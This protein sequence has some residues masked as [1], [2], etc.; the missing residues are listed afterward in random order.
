MPSSRP[1]NE[2]SRKSLWS[3]SSKWAGM[4]GYLDKKSG[5]KVDQRTLR[6]TWHRRYFDLPF[7]QSTLSYYKNEEA[8]NKKQ[9]AL[10][11]VEC[12]R[13]TVV[14]K[15]VKGET[16]R[17]SIE[18]PA[19]ELKLRAHTNGDYDAWLEALRPHATVPSES[20]TSL[21]SESSSS[22]SRAS[23][24]GGS[25]GG[26]K[27][28]DSSS[29][30][31][32]GYLEKKS[33]GSEGDHKVQHLQKWHK[34]WFVMQGARLS[35]YKTEESH[36]N[37]KAA[38]GSIECGGATVVS[39]EVKDERVRFTVQT[40]QRALKLRAPSEAE[41]RRWCEALG[42][43]ATIDIDVTV[44][45]PESMRGSCSELSE[46]SSPSERKSVSSGGRSRAAGM[47]G[48][49]DKRAEEG[50][51]RW[52][53]RYLFLPLGATR[54][55]IYKSE[56]ERDDG[57]PPLEHVQCGG[58][59]VSFTEL[60]YNGKFVFTLRTARREIALRTPSEAT[61]RDWMGAFKDCCNVDDDWAQALKD[62]Q[63]RQAELNGG[64]PVT[65]AS[66]RGST[67]E[68]DMA[69]LKGPAKGLRARW[70]RRKEEA[71][72]EARGALNAMK[73]IAS[74]KTSQAVIGLQKLKSASLF[75]KK[76]LYGCC[77]CC[78]CVVLVIVGLGAFMMFKTYTG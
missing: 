39:R 34:R 61:L 73:M 7:G 31:V 37:G 68:G 19:R 53:A 69:P 15:K 36:Q 6:E 13:A 47:E 25:L 33:G 74:G 4:R 3:P 9:A 62:A 35:Y 18:T 76:K 75:D 54:L 32:C 70:R 40:A 20:S 65:P 22:L 57:K 66:E 10:G 26:A 60:T 48:A 72:G 24:L 21:R 45:S 58:A 67:A 44:G 1:S 2:S 46:G 51:A 16:F 56:K 5:G 71:K 11:S 28:G 12:A 78:C 63:K 55:A 14:L 42:R 43:V 17:F 59:S 50:R 52:E 38:L 23:L 27:I 29:D 77:A 41:H 64:K 30:A 49:L 8:F